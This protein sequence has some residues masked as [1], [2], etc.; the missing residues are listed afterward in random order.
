MKYFSRGGL[1]L[2]FEVYVPSYFHNLAKPLDARDQMLLRGFASLSKMSSPSLVPIVVSEC[3]LRSLAA[4][5]D[6]K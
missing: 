4:H 5:V 1:A 6:I 3:C 2:C